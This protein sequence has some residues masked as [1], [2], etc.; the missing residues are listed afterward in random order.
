MTGVVT[1][2]H[3]INAFEHMVE[4]CQIIG[5]DWR[6]LYLNDAASRHGRRARHELLGRK[7]TEVWPGIEDTPL[8]ISLRRCLEERTQEQIQTEF[9]FPDS[10]R[11]QFELIIEPVPEGA[12]I[13]S[14]D[15]VEQRQAQERFHQLSLAVEQSPVSIIIT[16]ARGNIEYVNPKFIQLTGYS[17]DEVIGKNPRILKSGET[18]RERYEELW[19]TI[20]SGREWHGEF[21]NKKKNGELYWERAS[22]SPVKNDRGDITHF[23]AVKED[24]TA[25]RAAEDSLLESEARYR[26]LF[27]HNPN[28]MWIYD[29]ETL[30]IVSVNEMA[31][32]H[33]GYTREEFLAMTIADIHPPE[34]IPALL[35]HV[36][37]H[38]EDIQRSGTWRHRKKN[39]EIIEVEVT[40]HALPDAHGKHYRVVAV[41]DVS[42]RKRAEEA[43]R[44][45]E[46]R[47]REL[48]EY[49]PNPMLIYDESTFKIL[50]VN[51]I[52]ISHYG[53]SRAEFQTMTIADLHVPTDLP[54]MRSFISTHPGSTRKSTNWRHKKKDG[55][56]IDVEVSSHALPSHDGTKNR[57][58]VINDVT[59]RNRAEDAL[60]KSEEL[61]RMLIA[62]LPD[63]I[64]LA[65]I[66]GKISYASPNAYT[67]FGVSSEAEIIGHSPLEW[68]VPEQRAEAREAFGKVLSGV[69]ETGRRFHFMRKN[70]ETFWGESSAA[71]LTDGEGNITG[72]MLVTR[73]ISERKRAEEALQRAEE[74][75]RTMVER[76]TVGFYQTTPDGKL[77]TANTSFARMLGYESPEDMLTSLNDIGNSFYVDP[78]RRE[79]FIRAIQPQG[80]V[81]G[82]ESRAYRR[83]GSIMWVSEE[84]RAVCDD[85]GT[86]IRY[87]GTI[88]DITQR[89]RAEELLATER[90]TLRTLIDSLPDRIY[91]KDTECRFVLNNTAHIRRL[92][93]TRQQEVLGKTDF[94]FRPHDIASKSF[95]D[96]KR[97]I[98]TGKPLINKEEAVFSHTGEWE[99]LLTTK[100]P[101]RDKQGTVVGLVGISHDIT[102]RV[103]RDQER[104][105]L[106]TQ[107]KE[108]NAE[109]ERM[110]TDL[111]NM[112]GHLVQSEKMASL[113][114][115]VAGIAHE[116]NN[117]LAFVAS[118]LNRFKEYF[119]D[120]L[121]VLKEWQTVGK[122]LEANPLWEPQLRLLKSA[123]QQADLEFITEDFENLMRHSRDGAERIK[124]IVNK[125][126]GFART[127]GN[128]FQ[129]ANINEALEDTLTIVWN[130]L[131]YKATIQKEYGT[132]PPVV[133]NIGE[134]KQVFVNL[135]VNAAHAIA[136]KGVITIRT[137][138]KGENVEIQV[139][140]T[141]SGIAPEHLNKIF[142]PF[143]TTKPVGKGTGLGLWICM[144]IIQNHHGT[145]TV[146]SR[147]GQGTTFT[148]TLPVQQGERQATR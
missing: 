67:M 29:V 39:G 131:K 48:F 142:D 82:F 3:Y 4:G 107:L 50:D 93:C 5:F 114:Q 119:D 146:D 109:L 19:K 60:H 43:V 78:G 16:N 57:L 72:V 24:I 130:E 23:L 98:T 10:P 41:D 123:E 122:Q 128:E 124:S 80:S 30:Q 42:E 88:A 105:L 77:L 91:I 104:Q 26:A 1:T 116:I 37:R 70:G 69:V 7:F 66:D 63:A 53:Y 101:L 36:G 32:R 34:D 111:K 118:N 86:V 22:I 68:V 79:E 115:L 148:V 83:D 99:W 96:D 21:H 95:A 147:V 31:I 17:L 45:S 6:Y 102:E 92:G 127:S 62:T 20:R 97:V 141:G 85:Q 59:E 9:I 12:F 76:A 58:V 64:M 74:K 49:N 126:R 129:E 25:R 138:H 94:D 2:Q 51:E 35:S 106:E 13:L 144:T 140:D 145:I 136:E 89:K 87:E 100:V 15:L 46:A 33:C 121:T 90:N 134:L 52:A 81:T 54:A 117:P 56:V 8:F 137:A 47:Y 84:V 113:G 133:C 27:D 61:Y 14:I 120:T 108:R 11:G 75:Y 65:G 44:E 125:M 28:P 110:V 112:Q 132:L 38:Q 135:L 139:A 103:R 143:F 40:S 18:P 71:T 73:D 55:T